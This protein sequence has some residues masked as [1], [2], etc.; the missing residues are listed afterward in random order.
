MKFVGAMLLVFTV[1]TAVMTYPQILHLR[2]GVHD[3]GDPLL[4]TWALAW[5][6]HQLPRAPAHLFDA[7]IFYPERRTLA[8]SETL[9]LPAAFAAPLHWLGV[10][11]LLVYNVVFLSGFIVS[12]AGTALLVRT[13]TNSAAAGC[14]AGLVFAFLPYRI[15]HFPHLQLQQTQCL[16]FAMWAFHRLLQMG[17]LRDGVLFG[18]FTAGQILSCMYYGLFLLPYMAVVC[19]AM[20]IAERRLPTDRVVALAVAAAI[21][22]AAVIPVGMAY[23]GARRVVGER[24]R[25]EVVDGS[26]TWRNYLAPAEANALY[27]NAFARFMQSERRLFP[28]FVAMALAVVALL[29]TLASKHEST[30]PRNH[31][32]N[33]Y[34]RFVYSRFRVFVLSRFRGYSTR[35]AYALGLLLA[36]DVSLGFNGFTYPVMYDYFL[37]FRALRIPARMGLFVGFSLAVLAGYGIARIA[38]RVQSATLRRVVFV[39]AGVLMLAEYASKP[40]EL[41]AIR[42]GAPEVYAD[43]IRDR[44]DSPTAALFEFPASSQDDPTYLYYSTFHWQNLVNGYSGFFP[45]SYVRLMDAMRALPDDGSLSALRARGTRYL[46]VHGERLYGDR[47]ETLIPLLDKRSDLALVS[48]RPWFDRDKHS[49]ISAYRLIYAR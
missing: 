5:V 32:K 14:I 33:L 2:D 47:Y 37:P 15:D 9:L 6:A 7:N 42:T 49:E 8:Y 38:N 12:G 34:G 31:E 43:I 10:G 40:I 39:T 25:Q 1:L 17:R 28:G 20:L 48:R 19:G 11:P 24:G 27:G 13:L 45:P 18:A 46:V 26:A 30:K 36:F 29:P 21:A 44:G 35:F 22:L 23:L 4:N 16:P 41:A 3:D